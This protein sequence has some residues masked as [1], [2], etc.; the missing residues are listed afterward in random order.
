MIY[1]GQDLQ[2]YFYKVHHNDD[3]TIKYIADKRERKN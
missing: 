1:T 2:P 3:A